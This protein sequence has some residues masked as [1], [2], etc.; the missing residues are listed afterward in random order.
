MS[1]LRD[2]VPR[3]AEVAAQV[4]EVLAPVHLGR[5]GQ[6]ADHGAH[7]ALQ[8]ARGLVEGECSPNLETV[9]QIN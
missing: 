8:L 6:G 4:A 3:G 7:R 5:A 2:G 1:E 9:I